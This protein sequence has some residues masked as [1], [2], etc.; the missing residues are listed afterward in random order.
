MHVSRGRSHKPRN[1]A[2][3]MLPCL[4]VSFSLHSFSSSRQ[5][6]WICLRSLLSMGSQFCRGGVPTGVCGEGQKQSFN[7]RV[8]WGQS[9][10][11]GQLCR[12][13][14]RREA[15]YFL[16]WAIS[17]QRITMGFGT[18]YVTSF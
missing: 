16:W 3:V 14:D 4:S 13:Q 1:S 7:W 15:F 12:W 8:S 18:I 6:P 11:A 9:W 5:Q 10:A 17:S 2:A